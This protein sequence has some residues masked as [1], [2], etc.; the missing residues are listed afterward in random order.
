MRTFKQLDPDTEIGIVAK[1]NRAALSSGLSIFDLL[2][3]GKSFYKH[4]VE[5]NYFEEI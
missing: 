5:D 2:Y 4:I 1:F 3:D